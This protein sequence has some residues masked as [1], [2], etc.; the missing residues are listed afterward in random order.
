V[1]P[2]FFIIGSGRCGTTLMHRLLDA[3]PQIGVCNEGRVV[4]ALQFMHAFAS[5][6]AFDEQ[7]FSFQFPVRL[8]GWVGRP[9]V[10]AFARTIAEFAP[11]ILARFFERQFPDQDHALWGDKLPGDTST[12]GLLGMLPDTRFVVLSRDPR[13]VY[14]SWQSYTSR[15]DVI[16]N[17]PSMRPPNADQLAHSWR[18]YYDSALRCLPHKIHVR[19]P[20]LLADAR[21]E[22]L[23]VMAFLGLPLAPEQDA[24]LDQSQ[25]FAEHGT[26]A[27]PEG[28]LGRW[29][30]DLG[31]EER[32]VI[33]GVCGP[34]MQSLGYPLDS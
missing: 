3:H 13:D 12:A 15:P 23:R 32:A 8:H 14:C 9:Y 33:E 26:S 29:R 31:A 2:L 34:L 19:Y 28:S 20:D 6:P 30:R 5:L 17:N 21:A 11:A 27:S 25:L 18:N 24:A 22:L 1:K 7:D 10:D 4:E 16:A